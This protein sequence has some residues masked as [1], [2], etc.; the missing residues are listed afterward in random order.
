M[1]SGPHACNR[2]LRSRI[3][4]S[5]TEAVW[6]SDDTLNNALHRYIC[7]Q[8]RHGSSVPGPL[9]ARRRANKRRNTNL[10]SNAG[11]HAPID[12]GALLG[13]GQQQ[14]WWDTGEKSQRGKP[15]KVLTDPANKAL[16][17]WLT[18]FQPKKSSDSVAFDVG[19]R[20]LRTEQVDLSADSSGRYEQVLD[21]G[22]ATDAPPLQN[23]TE[24]TFIT[25]LGK[26]KDIGAIKSL[27]ANDPRPERYHL[28][29]DHVLVHRWPVADVETLLDDR[30]IRCPTQQCQV[31]ILQYLSQVR[32]PRSLRLLQS[33]EADISMDRVGKDEL[34]AIFKKLP[35]I[36]LESAAGWTTLQHSKLL[37]QCYDQLLTRIEK[38]SILSIRDLGPEVVDDISK[39]LENL[40]FDD[41]SVKVAERLLSHCPTDALPS[42]SRLVSYWV[43]S[44]CR[45]VTSMNRKRFLATMTSFLYKLQP[46][47]F[48]TLVSLTSEHLVSRVVQ[49]HAGQDSILTWDSILRALPL[50]NECLEDIQWHDRA[51][52]DF[53]GPLDTTQA[54]F[55][56]IWAA[57]LISTSNVR[58]RTSQDHHELLQTLLQDFKHTIKRDANLIESLV[59][60]ARSLPIQ[61]SR[62]LPILIDI[63][64][65][66]TGSGPI[67]GQLSSQLSN[68]LADVLPALQDDNAYHSYTN[69]LKDKLATLSETVN[70]DLPRFTK[71][72]RGLILHDKLSFRIITRLLNHNQPFK[73]ALSMSA[74][75]NT[76]LQADTFPLQ[77]LK[78]VND[79][80]TAFA[81]SPGV[82]SSQAYR[83]VRWCYLFLHRHGAPIRPELTRALF[84]AGVTRRSQRTIDP[85]RFDWIIGQVREV[86]GSDVARKL[87]S[88][89]D[90]GYE[91][92]VLRQQSSQKSSFPKAFPKETVPIAP[93]SIVRKFL[94]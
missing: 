37:H 11:N 51:I 78:T 33:I 4:A 25:L 39:H 15:A 42:L 57:S 82:S 73:N 61:S 50:N 86:E 53:E 41:G 10:A 9:E 55:I 72:A 94:S 5:C 26:A 17:S 35:P 74:N 75:P 91:R 59:A 88:F 12:V 65:P 45:G 67:P 20:N 19:A 60:T 3:S 1:I 64:I 8:K 36:S 46:R 62:M 80:A 38:S 81:C 34:R 48:T 28:A 71:H 63:V 43:E 90:P 87:A 47:T 84:H 77:C 21:T 7:L 92:A 79:L 13:S 85:V 16:P 44:I 40:S 54:A 22:P 31:Q 76:I 6:I 2:M 56:R 27:L 70:S 29:V 52:A 30:A 18:D 93:R 23:V 89:G 68:L 14:P 66:N 83:K 24:A 32:D 69:F 49:S 58:L